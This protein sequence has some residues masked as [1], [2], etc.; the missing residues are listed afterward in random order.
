MCFNDFDLVCVIGNW[1]II[2]YCNFS[3]KVLG[4]KWVMKFFGF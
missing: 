3:D 1:V 2:E 4:M